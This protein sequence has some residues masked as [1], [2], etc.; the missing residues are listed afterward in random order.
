MLRGIALVIN[1]PGA[2][3]VSLCAPHLWGQAVPKHIF[4]SQHSRTD[5]EGKSTIEIV[6]ILETLFIKWH[7]FQATLNCNVCSAIYLIYF[8]KPHYH[9]ITQLPAHPCIELYCPVRSKVRITAHDQQKKKHK[10]ISHFRTSFGTIYVVALN[11]CRLSIRT[12]RRDKHT[13]TH[14]HTHLT[15]PN[16]NRR[17]H[18]IRRARAPRAYLSV[19]KKK[20]RD[21]NRALLWCVCV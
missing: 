8:T 11:L 13:Q 19:V 16:G 7:I 12:A 9:P 14:T 21:S 10:F 18:I 2:P 20:R 4:S 6:R 15:N 1:F 3:R 5:G 17:H